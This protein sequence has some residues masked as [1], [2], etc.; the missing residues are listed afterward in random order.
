[1]AE[2]EHLEQILDNVP[3]GLISLDADMNV[4]YRNRSAASIAPQLEAGVNIWDALTPIVNEEKI[5]R[6]IRGER[7]LFKMGPD[8]PLLEW[9]MSDSRP[10]DGSMVLM[11]WPAV[12][13]DEIIQGRT[14]F[15]MGAS[16]ELRSPLTALLGFAEI[17]ELQSDSLTPEQAEAAR[18]IRRNAEHLHS[19]VDDIIDLSRNSFGELRLDTEDLDIPEIVAGVSE[20]LR[21][22]IE[23]KGQILRL[24]V[25]SRVGPIE[26]DRHRV[27]QIVFNL[28]QN[29]HKHTPSGTTIEVLADADGDGVR[30]TV[31][32]DGGG[33]PFEE[34]E[35]AFASFR[36]GPFDDDHHD[37]AGSGIGL[38][39]TRRVVELHRGTIEVESESGVGTAFV[40]WLPSDR[41]K[42]R[43][44]VPPP[45]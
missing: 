23:A 7:V 42:A 31:E 29:A 28:L 11:A 45:E 19:M 26:A 22:Q 43:D 12:I 3:S 32:D 41:E 15:I 10:A 16:H 44:L 20:T 1:M 25:E 2:A 40:V 5:D 35:D 18:V 4:V 6:V 27:R 36:R 13:T 39:I 17:L 9:L 37:I 14:T 33:L 34:A 30:I 21:P 8:L 24:D 38:T